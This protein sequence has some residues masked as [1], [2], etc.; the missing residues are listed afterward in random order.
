MRPCGPLP[1][2]VTQCVSGRLVGHY[3]FQIRKQGDASDKLGIMWLYS[4]SRM[5]RL[6]LRVHF[7]AL[8]ISIVLRGAEVEEDGWSG[9]DVATRLLY[10]DFTDSPP[11]A[12]AKRSTC[13]CVR[14][15]IVA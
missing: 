6:A 5:S 11:A 12:C 13:G 9:P 8:L 4:A 2:A 10:V 3:D 1:F 7:L 15:H 14:M